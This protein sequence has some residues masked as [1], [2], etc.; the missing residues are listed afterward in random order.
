MKSLS[1]E[2]DEGS[3]C[4]SVMHWFLPCEIALD[5]QMVDSVRN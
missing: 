3:E 5:L 4:L 2:V 1:R